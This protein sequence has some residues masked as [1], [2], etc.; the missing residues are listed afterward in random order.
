MDEACSPLRHSPDRPTPTSAD[1]SIA[2]FHHCF[3]KEPEMKSFVLLI[4][5]ATVPAL[6]LAQTS[7]NGQ[8]RQTPESTAKKLTRAEL[9]TLLARPGGVLLLDV[10]RPDEL[11]SIGGFP[12]FLS[13]QAG[14]LEQYLSFIPKDRLIVPVSNHAARAGRAATT[15][16][17]HGFKVAGV[18]GAQ[19][20]EAEGGTLVKI[21]APPVKADA[22]R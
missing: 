12:V 2:V 11:Q 18:I 17:Q 7:G 6:A 15:L 20:Y 1:Q 14:E 22:R 8:R 5:L 10:R 9:D 4:V 16:E 21:Q 13:I 19:D 3:I